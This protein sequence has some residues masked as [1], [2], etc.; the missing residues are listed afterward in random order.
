MFSLTSGAQQS[1]LRKVFV[2]IKEWRACKIETNRESLSKI[3]K[4]IKFDAYQLETLSGEPVLRLGIPSISNGAL[5]EVFR[6]LKK[7]ENY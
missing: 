3:V 6:V 1:C 7:E 5:I 4:I 2:K